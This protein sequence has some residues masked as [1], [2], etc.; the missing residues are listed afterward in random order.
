MS[1]KA[2]LFSVY[3]I[4]ILLLILLP[5]NSNESALN[6]TYVLHVR[7]DYLGHVVLFLPWMFLKPIKTVK[8]NSFQWFIIG[9]IFASFTECIQYVVP[10]RAFNVNDMLANSMGVI[11]SAVFIYFIIRNQKIE[12]TFNR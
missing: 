8:I 12:S 2:V 4:V 11:F 5:I 1:K 6:N 9:L 10:Y 3:V 7:A